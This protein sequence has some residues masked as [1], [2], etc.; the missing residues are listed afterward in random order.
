MSNFQDY[1]LT[2][3]R[4]AL[5][6]VCER[7]GF[8]TKDQFSYYATFQMNEY[9]EQWIVDKEKL[10]RMY[11]SKLEEIKKVDFEAAELQ[12]E[13]KLNCAKIAVAAERVKPNRNTQQPALQ[14]TN[15][16][17]TNCFTTSGYTRC[18]TN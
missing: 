3:N 18:T 9:P 15:P 1:K 10:Q 13:L 5:A 16:T 17:T 2:A 7:Q 8:I 11:F 12:E 14:S 6:N 4:T